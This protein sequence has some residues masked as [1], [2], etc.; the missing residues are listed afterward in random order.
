[1]L[2]KTKPIEL[3]IFF[4]RLHRQNTIAADS[5]KRSF[6]KLKVLCPLDSL[7][8]CVD[9]DLFEALFNL[10]RFEIR[11]HMP[12]PVPLPVCKHLHALEDP[13]RLQVCELL[14]AVARHLLVVFV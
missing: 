12:D 11:A 5:F 2:L 14:L 10:F 1:M 13:P 4:R 8:D 7:L 9:V 3:S 6:Q